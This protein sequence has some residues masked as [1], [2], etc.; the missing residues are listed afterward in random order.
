[1]SSRSGARRKIVLPV[2]VVRSHLNQSQLAHTVDLSETS[3][4]LGGLSMLLE[5]GETVEI[6][7]EGLTAKFQVFW[8]GSRG[9]AM[10]GQAGI[11]S[12]E[13]DNPI[14][15]LGP[16]EASGEPEIG[17]EIDVPVS[18]PA[19]TAPLPGEKRWHARLECSGSAAVQSR[20]AQFPVKGQIKDVSQGGIYVEVTTP[21]AVKSKVFLE[22][23]IEG[24][25]LEAT[26]VVRTSYPMVGMG[27][28]FQEVTPENQPK[29]AKILEKVTLRK[30]GDQA[31]PLSAQ[32]APAQGAK[33]PTTLRLDAYP[34]RVLVMACQALARDFDQWKGTHS[35]AEIDELRRAVRDLHE[36]LSAGAETGT[37]VELM[38]YAS[39]SHPRGGV[40]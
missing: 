40:A 4:R 30:L 36:K 23:N 24:I 26:G 32:V 9:T 1:M 35:P 25:A 17:T 15:G 38:G 8:M 10:E 5:P 7:R 11:R 3:A 20:G 14:W 6:H 22:M 39:T 12:L 37:Q 13:P 33:P 34:I 27:I 31:A 16:K 29:L 21:L 28:S 18:L 19:A 2:T